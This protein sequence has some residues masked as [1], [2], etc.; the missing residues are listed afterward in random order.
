MFLPELWQLSWLIVI[1][2]GFPRL[3]QWVGWTYTMNRYQ[4]VSGPRKLTFWIPHQFL[5]TLVLRRMAVQSTLLRYLAIWEFPVDVSTEV[6]DSW[7]GVEVRSW[8]C[9][10]W[11]TLQ[12]WTSRCSCMY[13]SPCSAAASRARS[14]GHC[15]HLPGVYSLH[16]LHQAERYLSSESLRATVRFTALIP[17]PRKHYNC[18]TKN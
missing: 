9:S 10:S 16:A 15:D 13:R 14:H 7:R 18:V 11:L 17:S 4:W 8:G 2:F 5:A 3:L 12:H 6:M 1:L